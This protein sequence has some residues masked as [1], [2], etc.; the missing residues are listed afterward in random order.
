MVAT[1][2]HTN[3]AQ[4]Q[5]VDS[6]VLKIWLKPGNYI[7]ATFARFYVPKTVN[8]T[9][10]PADIPITLVR[11]GQLVIQAKSAQV[12][13]LDAIGARF[14]GPVHPGINGPYPTIPPGS[15]MLSVLD[16]SGAVVSNV[17]VAITA[18]ETTT[19]QL[20]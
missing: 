3:Q 14:P 6:G 15:Y 5:R 16:S 18:G 10:P 9:T 7:A 13:R 2:Q 11:G 19:I 12:L 1:E 20:P 17:P 4:A 8:F